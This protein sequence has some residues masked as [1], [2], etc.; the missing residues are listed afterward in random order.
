MK[1]YKVEV[2]DNGA[3]RWYNEEGRYHRE[4]GPAIESAGGSRYWYI[5]DKRLTE[6][7][8]N[9]RKKPCIGKKVIIDGIEYTLS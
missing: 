7:E 6:E 9:N 1:T 5:N 3:T 4:D 2:N 8:F